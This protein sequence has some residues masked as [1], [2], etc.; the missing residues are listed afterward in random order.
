MVDNLHII[1]DLFPFQNE[2]PKERSEPR[3]FRTGF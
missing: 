3:E 2:S 1:V